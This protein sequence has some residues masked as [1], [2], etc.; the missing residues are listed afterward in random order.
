VIVLIFYILYKPSFWR[1]IVF[2]MIAAVAMIAIYH[3]NGIV[4]TKVDLFVN[5]L[6]QYPW[7]GGLAPDTS[8]SMR[9]TFYRIGYY[10]FG[11]SPLFGWGERGYGSIKDATELLSFSTQYTRDFAFSALFHSEWATQ[12]VRFGALALVGVFW[13]F[14]WPIKM[15]AQFSKLGNDHLK[16]A[17][18]GLAYMICLLAASIGD[19]VF[20]H[21]MSVSFSAVV[22]A[23]LLATGFSLMQKNHHVA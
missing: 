7:S 18:M 19:E 4:K 16:V 3:F 10:Y 9:I 13:V 5:E 17:C 14:Y 21:K 1:G 20:N 11:Q 23:G 15:F 12:S 8:T 2:S 6:S 22:I